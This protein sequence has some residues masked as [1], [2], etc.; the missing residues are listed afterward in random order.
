[1]SPIYEFAALFFS[2]NGVTVWRPETSG[3]A[4]RTPQCT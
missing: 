3:V 2:V 1:M 4:Q